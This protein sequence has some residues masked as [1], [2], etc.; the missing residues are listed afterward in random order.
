MPIFYRR[1]KQRCSSTGVC[2]SLPPLAP[3]QAHFGAFCGTKAASSELFHTRANKRFLALGI[4]LGKYLFT[5]GITGRVIPIIPRCK[6]VFPQVIPRLSP[7]SVCPSLPDPGVKTV[8]FPRL[9]PSKGARSRHFSSLANKYFP[10]F[11]RHYYY[12]YPLYIKRSSRD[13][14]RSSLAWFESTLASRARG[15]AWDV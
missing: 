6:Q 7:D 3:K 12:C 1:G 2:P 8:G 13:P 14:E 4:N 15:R 10:L 9:S 5:L 11:H